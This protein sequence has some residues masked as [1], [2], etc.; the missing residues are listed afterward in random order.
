MTKLK[1]KI[2]A[3]SEQINDE[4][5]EIRAHLHAHPEL[6]FEEFETSKF[7]QNYLSE[8]GVPY[9][10]GF[11]KTGI[12]G[13]I[14]G[15]N[16]AKKVIALRSDM[17]ALPINENP[18]NK[19]CSRNKGVMHAC[20]HDM[21]MA[22]LLGTAKILSEFKSEWEGT[23]LLIFQPGEE[24]LPGGAKLMMEEGALQPEPEWIIGQ[25][26]LP[27]MPAGTIGF[28]SGMYMASGD[29]IYLTVKGKGGHAAM[30]HKCT[31]TILIASHIIVALQQ[32]VSRH[33]DARIPTVLSFGKMIADGA[34][35]IIPDEVKIEGT[36]RTMNEEWRAKAKQLIADIAQS[37]AKGMGAVC[38]VDI[39]HGYPFLVNHED[40]THEAKIN[41]IELLG[42]EKVVNMDIRMTTEDFG[43]YSQKYPVTFYRF[44]VQSEKNGSLHTSTFEANDDSLRTSMSTM[45]WLA[46][47][48]LNK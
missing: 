9:K 21:H 48:Y 5:K 45:A 3:F 39:R 34:T 40:L 41:A 20:G 42:E 24:L 19:Y 15:K 28:R 12:V 25:H 13:K 7:I 18:D 23:I 30:P 4:I 27:D 47:S 38:E 22:S 29:E 44:G 16:P 10:Y 43:F 11:V 31:D 6:S 36:F 32:I 2:L 33:C 46:I 1:T 35:N 37:T 8:L 14:E 17:D 26:V